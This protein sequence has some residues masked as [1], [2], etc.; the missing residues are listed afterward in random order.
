MAV[1]I[2][3]ALLSSLSLTHVL[4]SFT[5]YI[6]RIQYIDGPQ[7]PFAV[8]FADVTTGPAPLTVHLDAS[9]SYDVNEN[10][11]LTYAWDL[12]GDGTF[13]DALTINTSHTFASAGVYEV[14]L[15]VTDNT[16]LN[17][18]FTQKIVV[19]F[20]IL[21]N[22]TCTTKGQPCNQTKWELGDHVDFSGV[23]DVYVVVCV[24]RVFV[25]L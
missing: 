22:I 4:F 6:A 21:T 11:T 17:D 18:T 3:M 20:N 1:I 24:V 19:G 12:D 14:R 2:I 8:I 25:L 5:G 23:C 9:R 16:G 7:A 13:K 15:L 10:D